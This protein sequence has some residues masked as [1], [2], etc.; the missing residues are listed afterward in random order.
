MEKLVQKQIKKLRL[1][2]RKNFTKP[3]RF[4]VVSS[5]RS[6]S[7]YLMSMF[8]SHPRIVQN[9]EIFGPKVLKNEEK[10]G[11]IKEKGEINYFVNSFHR[12]GFEKA[13][14]SKVLYSYFRDEYIK[15]YPSV[16]LE[17]IY[18]YLSENKDIRIV[19]LHRENLLRVILSFEIANISKVYVTLEKKSSNEKISLSKEFLVGRLDELICE[20]DM[21]REKFKNHPFFEIT[22]EK[23]VSGNS[24]PI[25]KLQRFLGVDILRLTGRTIKQNDRSISEILTNYTQLKEEFSDTIYAEYFID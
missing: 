4:V 3:V 2:C 21:I 13:R 16:D 20:R 5:G 19:H 18:T 25:N 14:G 11:E 7:N 12:T 22:Y 6:G 10:V 9:G 15:R 23:M 24:F 1:Y 17:K 8:D